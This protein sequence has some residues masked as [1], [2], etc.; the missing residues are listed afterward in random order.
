M[1]P[2]RFRKLLLALDGVEAVP[3]MGR[4]AFRTPR[5]IFVTLGDDGSVNLRIVPAERREALMDAFP[6]VFSSLGGWTRLGYVAV[7]LAAVESELLTEL[8]RDAW[9]DAL[10]SERPARARKARR[11]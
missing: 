11:A 4:T 9:R 5:R 6:A 1:T 3:H 10:P 7:D 8:V 2:A